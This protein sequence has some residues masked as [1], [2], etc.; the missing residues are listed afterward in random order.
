MHGRSH[1]S[2]EGRSDLGE[3][4]DGSKSKKEKRGEYLRSTYCDV[5]GD[6]YW[7]VS[8]RSFSRSLECPTFLWDCKN[9]LHDTRNLSD[10]PILP[11]ADQN[12]SLIYA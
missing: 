11:G 10:M 3:G 9:F 4:A 5:A 7:E 2:S 8:G 12:P 1:R 6:F